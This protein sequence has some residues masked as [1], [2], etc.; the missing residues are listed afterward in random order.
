M[1]CRELNSE[2]NRFGIGEHAVIRR[3]RVRKP[4]R[5]PVRVGRDPQVANSRQRG[6]AGAEVLEGEQSVWGL[7]RITLESIEQAT[8]PGRR[9]WR[10]AVPRLASSHRSHLKTR[11]LN[12]LLDDA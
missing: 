7:Q 5:R 10:R 6:T 3:N 8:H 9:R 2:I 1:A 4:R 11:E 12:S